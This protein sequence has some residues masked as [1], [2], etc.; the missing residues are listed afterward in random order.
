MMIGRHSPSA[1]FYEP[2]FR[3]VSLRPP[4]PAAYFDE[5]IMQQI[6]SGAHVKDR[7]HKLRSQLESTQVHLAFGISLH[8]LSRQQ[9]LFIKRGPCLIADLAIPSRYPHNWCQALTELSPEKRI[10]NA[11]H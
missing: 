5:S 11:E 10:E 7:R 3:L 1:T 9:E 8:A 2:G 6:A 4:F